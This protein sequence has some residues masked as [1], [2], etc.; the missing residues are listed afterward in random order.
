MSAHVLASVVSSVGLGVVGVWAVYSGRAKVWLWDAMR[1]LEGMKQ[2][3]S[4]FAVTGDSID[5]GKN[6]EKWDAVTYFMKPLFKSPL[7]MLVRYPAG[8]MNAPH[9]HP[10]GHGMYVLEGSLV[11]NR[12]T[13]GPETFVWFPPGEMMT[14]GAG[15]DADLVLL[16][17]AQ[18]GVRT[19]YPQ[20]NSL[21]T[22]VE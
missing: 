4:F 14:H 8:Q 12:G 15:N 22:R 16:L 5:W 10:V 17:I 9:S 3:S 1:R 18:R 13:F 7:V 11:T 20:Q 2:R 21:P 19:D 6:Q